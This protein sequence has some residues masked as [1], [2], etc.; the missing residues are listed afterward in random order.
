MPDSNASTDRL[1]G[2][3]SAKMD[4][5]REDVKD[6]KGEVHGRLDNHAQR[7]ALLEKEQ[8][9][10]QGGARMLSMLLGGAVVIGGLLSQLLSAVI[11]KVWP[12]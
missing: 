2:Q 5:V 10:R 7:I 11:G 6:L 12:T 9:N 3:L 1:L 4:M 8:S